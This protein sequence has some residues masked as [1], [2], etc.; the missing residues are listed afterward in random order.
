MFSIAAG[1]RAVLVMFRSEFL[2]SRD[3]FETKVIYASRSTGELWGFD[4]IPN[5]VERLLGRVE[6]RGIAG[7]PGENKFRATSQ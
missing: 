7:E 4:A 6:E 1:L 5:V 3:R 2:Q